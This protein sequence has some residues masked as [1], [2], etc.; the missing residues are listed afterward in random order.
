MNSMLNAPSQRTC[1]E[2]FE[3]IGEIFLSDPEKLHPEQFAPFKINLF[4][5]SLQRLGSVPAE[6]NHSL[7]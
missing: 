2:T 4:E 1:D 6:Q 5:G 7:I 3:A